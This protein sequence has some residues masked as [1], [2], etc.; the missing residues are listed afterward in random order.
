MKTAPACALLAALCCGVAAPA[1]AQAQPTPPAQQ[2]DAAQPTPTTPKPPATTSTAPI[3]PETAAAIETPTAPTEPSRG[4]FSPLSDKLQEKGISL[5]GVL[6]NQFA[7]NTQGG[8]GQGDT[9]VGQLNF[10]ADVNLEKAFGWTGS[11]FHVTVY[12]DYGSGL[13]KDITGTFF[14]QQNIYKNEFTQLHLG[15]FAFEQKLFDGK[16]DLIAGRVGTTSY[17]GHLVPGCEF[18]AGTT[19]GIPVVLNSQAGFG[20]LPRPPG[21][22]TSPTSRPSTPTSR[23]ARSR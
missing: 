1:L 17:Y 12:R 3:Q 2:G 8:V 5:R 23:R 9:N 4:V 16:L 20:L 22:A 7:K 18:Q 13:A 21:A 6:I 11:S 14:K 19:C 10:G 15:L